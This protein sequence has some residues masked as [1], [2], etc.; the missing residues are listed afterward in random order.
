MKTET[1]P[2]P[3]ETVRRI[4]LA[5]AIISDQNTRQPTPKDPDVRELAKSIAEIGQTTPA[6]VRP[7]PK[8]KGKYEIG[9]GAKRRLAC[10]I[11]KNETFD[12][13]VRE[14]NDDEFE[15]LIL[16]ENLQRTDPDPVQEVKLLKRLVDR[17]VRTVEQI[18][19][20]LGKGEHWVK[21]RLPLLKVIPEWLKRWELP[22]DNW[23][24][25]RGYTPDMMAM[26]GALPEES[27]RRLLD[28]NMQCRNRR[29][30]A[31]MLDREVFCR[32]DKA[33]WLDDPRTFLNGCGPGCACDSSKTS[34]FPDLED[35]KCARCTNP[36]CFFAR[37]AKARELQ[38]ADLKK[39]HG[40]LPI[41][42]DEYE[43]MRDGIELAGEKIKPERV[44]DVGDKP[45]SNK[46]KVI[47]V[48][49]SGTMRVGYAAKPY[50]GGNGSGSKPKKSKAERL[51]ERKNIL[52]GQR[53]LLVHAELLKALRES[54]R[55]DCR[56]DVIDLAVI[57]G[58]PY[59]AKIAAPVCSDRREWREFDARKRSGFPVRVRPENL[60]GWRDAKS[61]TFKSREEALWRGL[62]LVLEEVMHPT[63]NVGDAIH[64]E[65]DMRRVA[66]LISFNFDAAARRAADKI[67]PPKTWGLVDRY[68][69]EPISARQ[70]VT[71]AIA[72]NK[73][74]KPSKRPC[75]KAR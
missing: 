51:R 53:L 73:K 39:E 43:Y 10:E 70:A 74:S 48:E 62:K 20:H 26:V 1:K 49:E 2:P 58:L 67:P 14:L 69:L 8:H 11:A 60:G 22:E 40:D 42:T 50:T 3:A 38:Y 71:R 61:E 27:Q 28:R 36:T 59:R 4:P 55:K 35:Q 75:K 25:I 18:S 72:R 13:I 31:R 41:V 23:K 33:T 56:E 37:A 6:I 47:V 21:R 64:H 66:K 46:R 63:G 54:T 15:E 7:H 17:G 12:A 30:L 9:A 65:K 24:S 44:W 16:V 19:S 32:L 45:A 57:F 29:E 5:D 52:R 68:T 34:L